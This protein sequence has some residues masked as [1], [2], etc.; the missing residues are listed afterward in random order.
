MAR[1]RRRLHHRG[2]R[3]GDYADAL[4]DAQSRAKWAEGEYAR[5]EQVTRDA[6]A[7]YD[8]DVSRARDKA[9]AERRPARS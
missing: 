5:G 8:A 3:A 7:S 9:H 1:V 6:Q 2:R 4:Q